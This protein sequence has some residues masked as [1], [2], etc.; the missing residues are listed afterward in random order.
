[1]TDPTRGAPSGPE[2]ATPGSYGQGPRGFRL[3]AGTGVGAVAL[4]IGHLAR[5]LVFYREVLGLRVVADGP[6]RATLAAYGD[7][8]VLL[9]L[10]EVPG[11]QAAGRPAR[12]GLFHFAILLPD[13]AA[14]GRL[15][16]HLSTTGIR[17]STG[18]HLVSE[19]LYLTDPDGLGVEVYADRPRES[20]RRVGRELQMAT[21]PVDVPGLLAAAGETAWAGMPPG[22]VMGHVHLHVG[23]IARAAEFYA[24]AMGLDKTTWSYPGALFLGAGGYHHHVGVNTWAGPGARPAGPD[25][26]RLL[27]WTMTLPDAASVQA[28]QA[29]LVAAGHHTAREDDAIVT[30]DPWGTAVRVRPR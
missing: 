5:S 6:G 10:M 18:D 29:S 17:V 16:R 26:A 22:T 7:D 15:Y 3:P 13:R 30:H 21:L 20:W 25:E 24:D 4:Q 27:E 8:R 9:D 1:M 14:L 23:D 28:L 19:A 2:P 11:T 12:L